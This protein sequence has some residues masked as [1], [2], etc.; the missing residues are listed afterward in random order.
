MNEVIFD[1]N[2]SIAN[3]Q[4]STEDINGLLDVFWHIFY[5]LKKE[6]KSGI[7]VDKIS[8]IAMEMVKIYYLEI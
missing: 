2:E 3:I 7:S 5:S 6:E 1:S 8:E 4:Q